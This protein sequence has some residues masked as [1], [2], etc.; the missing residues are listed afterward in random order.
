[1]AHYVFKRQMKKVIS[2]ALVFAIAALPFVQVKDY[3]TVNLDDY[4]YVAK[5]VDPGE[6][7][8]NVSEAIWMP[9]TWLDYKIDFA[10]AKKLDSGLMRKKSP[11]TFDIEERMHN[12]MHIHSLVIHSAN[13][14]LLLFLFLTLGLPLIPSALCALL[15]AVHPLRCESVCWI[16]S[17]KDVLSMFWLLTAMLAWIGRG[18]NKTRAIGSIGYWAALA[19]FVLSAMCKPSAML[20]APLIFI[21]DWL[22]LE[23]VDPCAD[24][25]EFYKNKKCGDER[26]AERTWLLCKRYI[27]YA[28]PLIACVAL[29]FFAGW[30][31]HAGGAMELTKEVGLGAKLINAVAAYGLYVKNTFCPTDLAPMLLYR[32]PG[33]PRF[34]WQGIIIAGASLL[35]LYLL[36]KI[37][38]SDLFG[39]KSKRM[40][41]YLA[42]MLWFMLSLLPFLGIVSFGAEPLADRFTYIASV[43]WS[44]AAAGIMLRFKG[45]F[46]RSILLV[47]VVS[48]IAFLMFSTYRQ[49]R[50]WENDKTVF[51][52]AIKV[53][54][55]HHHAA[56][57][58]LG[59]WHFD[60]PH[61]LK[62][63]IECFE[64]ALSIDKEKSGRIYCP[65]FFALYEVGNRDA[66]K[67][68]HQDFAIWDMNFVKKNRAG[69]Y[70]GYSTSGYLAAHALYLTLFKDTRKQ[71]V[72]ELWKI[73]KRCPDSDE[74]KYA[75]YLL[76][77]I[78]AH[79][80]RQTSVK[81]YFRYR[82]LNSKRQRD[83]L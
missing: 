61:N 12:I 29:A 46:H 81:N 2:A 77:E 26:L 63:S 23:R 83:V 20:F 11:S 56:W 78:K 42:G 60:N 13:A 38:F 41:F 45:E 67:K 22:L 3:G 39:F 68:V 31:Q 82:F 36:V 4:D 69:I 75:L 50:H 21:V 40:N 32:I 55:E 1:M 6:N 47:A 70:D 54:G 37:R 33:L 28:L 34:W 14:V 74:P 35:I 66:M 8:W 15:W 9:L 52:Q 58:N 79:E 10:V 49:T 44:F 53:E 71:A 7:V 24:I 16:A 76:G 73:A 18:G 25:A 30:A 72:E 59:L 27:P 19:C 51:E 43:G 57:A 62:K 80:L 48:A 5:A 65:Y 64:R 17:R